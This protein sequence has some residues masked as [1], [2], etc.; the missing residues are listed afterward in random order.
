[1]SCFTVDELMEKNRHLANENDELRDELSNL[2]KEKDQWKAHRDQLIDTISKLSEELSTTK[3]SLEA[4][5]EARQKDNQDMFSKYYSTFDKNVELEKKVKM[6]ERTV[7]GQRNTIFDLRI[8]SRRG[9]E[10]TVNEM[11]KELSKIGANSVMIG[12]K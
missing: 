7:E 5:L 9:K 11:L 8:R 1:M 10:L 2:E 3:S 4:S 12:L 6:L